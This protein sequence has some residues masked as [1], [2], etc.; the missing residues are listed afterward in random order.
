VPSPAAISLLLTSL[1]TT[2]APLVGLARLTSSYPFPIPTFPR[3]TH[4]RPRR[5]YPR[6]EESV[7][8]LHLEQLRVDTLFSR[9]AR[10]KSVE[11][12]G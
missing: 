1:V 3:A 6:R 5:S 11:I 12:Y 2:A 7:G 8:T 10:S 9:Q 4:L